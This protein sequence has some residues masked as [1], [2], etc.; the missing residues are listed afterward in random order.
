[1]ARAQPRGAERELSLT[2]QAR[3]SQ[4]IAVTIG[5]V[6]ERGHAGTSLAAMAQGAGITKAAVLYHFPTKDALVRAAY[7]HVL[8]ALVA[9]V[10]EA[11]EVAPVAERPAAY[12]RAMID[13]LRENPTHTR[14]LIEGLDRG[15]GDHG[16]AARW[17]P[18]AGLLEDARDALAGQVGSGG[19]VADS[20]QRTAAIMVGGAIDAIVSEQLR[21]PAYD[22]AAAAEELVAL[23]DLWLRR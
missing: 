20:D 14:M 13:H 8:D 22:T 18:V 23:L 12:V 19:V 5:L 9:D 10:G 17:R 16:S 7:E 1:M 21:D 2:E 4:L 6:A 11:V 15:E 3:R